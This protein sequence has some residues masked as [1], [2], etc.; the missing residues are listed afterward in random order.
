[1]Y[2]GDGSD[3]QSEVYANSPNMSL[4]YTMYTPTFGSGSFMIQPPKSGEVGN[5][6]PTVPY[7]SIEALFYQ[8]QSSNPL[9]SPINTLS[10]ANVGQQVVNGQ[11][12]VSDSTNTSRYMLGSQQQQ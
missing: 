1:M 6:F 2:E 5:A 10:G 7:L 12:T 3:F 4:M 9:S 8:Q 11:Y